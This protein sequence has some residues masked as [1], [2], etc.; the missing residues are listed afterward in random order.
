MY[1][2]KNVLIF[3]YIPE[4]CLHFRPLIGRASFCS[5]PSLAGTQEQQQ[6][7]H[8]HQQECGS[9]EAP[10]TAR[11]RRVHQPMLHASSNTSC[12][13]VT[14][15]SLFPNLCHPPDFHVTYISKGNFAHIYILFFS[16]H[17]ASPSFFSLRP[18][19]NSHSGSHSRLS[20]PLPL[21]VVP[22]M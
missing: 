14:F 12:D 11:M 6:H 5:T 21:P 7:L 9:A 19:R 20:S 13:Y 3:L 18:S 2:C 8:L 15:V 22:S 1:C 17:L 4:R 10:P 16:S